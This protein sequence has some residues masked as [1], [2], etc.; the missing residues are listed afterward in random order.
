MANLTD[1]ERKLYPGQYTPNGPGNKQGK[2]HLGT[3]GATGRLRTTE[4]GSWLSEGLAR[5]QGAGGPE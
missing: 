1:L 5:A 2:E 4:L 3:Q